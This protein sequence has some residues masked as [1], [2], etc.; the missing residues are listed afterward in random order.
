MFDFPEAK[1]YVTTIHVETAHLLIHGAEFAVKSSM[2]LTV[3]KTL[4][5]SMMQSSVH[6]L[7]RGWQKRSR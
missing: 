3:Q 1:R 5:L 6:G 4:M 2:G 7:K